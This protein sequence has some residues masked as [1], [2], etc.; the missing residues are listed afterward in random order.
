MSENKMPKD[1][2]K[3]TVE[4][5][6]ERVNKWDSLTLKE[7][8]AALIALYDGVVDKANALP[9]KIIGSYSYYEGEL[10]GIALAFKL[11]NKLNHD[12]VKNV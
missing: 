12:E 11:L 4:Q 1:Y 9:K 7:A 6:L 8:K 2:E 10:N 3:L 5:A